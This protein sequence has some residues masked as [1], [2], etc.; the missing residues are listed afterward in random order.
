MVGEQMKFF[1]FVSETLIQ[2]RRALSFIY[3]YRHFLEGQ[4]H[5]IEFLNFILQD[6]AR[7]LETLSFF[8]ESDISRFFDPSK[9]QA[10]NIF[11]EFKI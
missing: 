6:L 3:A 1:D 8:Q 9:P 10:M 5:K 7:D 4:T 11:N 2:S